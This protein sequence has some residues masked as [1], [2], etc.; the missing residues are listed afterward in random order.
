MKIKLSQLL[1]GTFCF[2]VD[3]LL[4]LDLALPCNILQHQAESMLYMTLILSRVRSK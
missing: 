2:T 1:R 3:L 4:D